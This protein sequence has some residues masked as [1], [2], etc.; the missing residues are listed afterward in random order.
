MTQ[1][2]AAAKR[3]ARFTVAQFHRLCDVLPEQRLELIAGE[4]LEVIAK[5]TR[6]TAVVHRL[7]KAIEVWLA[8]DPARA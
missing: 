5:G 8:A 4:V 1:A 7:I 3:H 6:H 2:S